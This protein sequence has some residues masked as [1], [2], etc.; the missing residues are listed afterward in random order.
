MKSRSPLAVSPVAVF[1]VHGGTSVRV[2]EGAPVPDLGSTS[3]DIRLSAVD[4]ED[5]ELPDDHAAFSLVSAVTVPPS[6]VAP[7]VP[8]PEPEPMIIDGRYRVVGRLGSGA[9]GVVYRAED[10]M[11]Q[12]PVAL[13]MIEPEMAKTQA[14]VDRF[15]SEARAL[16]RLRHDNVVQIYAF[17]KHELSYFFA[18]ELVDGEDLDSMLDEHF[19]NGTTMPLDRTLEIITKVAAGLTAAHS[20]NLVHRDVKPSNVMIERETGRPVLLDFGIV[21]SLGSGGNVEG[22]GTPSYMAPEQVLNDI[23]LLSHKVDVYALACTAFEMLTGRLVFLG[24]SVHQVM[25]KHVNDAPPLVSSIRPDL[26]ALDPT[27]S[28]ALAKSPQY[29]HDSCVHFAEELAKAL[30]TID[31]PTSLRG[32][33]TPMATPDNAMRVLVL[34]DDDGLRR[35]VVREASRALEKA[36]RPSVVECV[37]A[38]GTLLAAFARQPAAIVV[39]D[40]DRAG[41]VSIGLA[42]QLRTMHGGADADILVLTRD[43]LADRGTWE[44]VRARRVVKPFNARM[45]GSVLDEISGRVR[46]TG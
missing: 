8:E 24:D 42:A 15:F 6:C 14:A 9:M 35:A 34:A 26:A 2:R 33:P 10:I 5:E 4:T 11:L 36:R 37:D 29:R 41:G 18:M 17:G 43:M 31:A 28:R 1:Q 40:D 27:F 44:S 16:A 38:A 23:A 22:C 39:I 32:K 20:R 19:R 30:T 3:I 13:K 45:L 7:V 12:R 25:V 21:Q 46:R